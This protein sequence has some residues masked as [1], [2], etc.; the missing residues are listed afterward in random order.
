MHSNSRFC[1]AWEPSSGLA[2]GETKLDGLATPR[3]C[4]VEIDPNRRCEDRAKQ[5]GGH[6]R[7]E[8]C[9]FAVCHLTLDAIVTSQSLLHALGMVTYSLRAGIVF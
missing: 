4:P 3:G 2:G 8:R 7:L 9:I 1:C 6:L 5:K